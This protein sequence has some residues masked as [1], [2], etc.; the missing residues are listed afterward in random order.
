MEIPKGASVD[1]LFANGARIMS[2]GSRN[3]ARLVTESNGSFDMVKVE[4]SN[5]LVL[6]PPLDQDGLSKDEEDDVSSD[7]SSSKRARQSLVKMPSRKINSSFIELQKT[8]LDRSELYQML[9][10]CVFDPF[11]ECSV[12]ALDNGKVGWTISDLVHELRVSD[13][14]IIDA[15][16][17]RCAFRISIRN[18][19]SIEYKFCLLSEESLKEAFDALLAAFIEDDIDFKNCEI[20]SCIESATKLL[21]QGNAY[22][23]PMHDPSQIIKHC[24][25]VVSEGPFQ[26]DNFGTKSVTSLDID[27]V[28]ILYGLYSLENLIR[29]YNYIF[30][31]FA[32][33]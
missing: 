27:K 1:Q 29:C 3:P 10:K 23:T 16:Q 19:D 12:E 17:E 31:I 4:T 15:L 9:L 24:L 14:E 25:H 28:C 11:D 13:K 32:Q 20:D 6:V 18:N 21:G 2:A 22:N 7:A 5:C 8:Y 33:S 26:Y 30:H